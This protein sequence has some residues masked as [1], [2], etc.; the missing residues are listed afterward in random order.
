MFPFQVRSG[1]SDY[2]VIKFRAEQKTQLE[3]ALSYIPGYLYAKRP[4]LCLVPEFPPLP[5]GPSF[6]K[7]L[8]LMVWCL[9]SLCVTWVGECIP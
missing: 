5:A 3:E 7:S 2:L 4:F 1:V 9:S 8:D 6:L